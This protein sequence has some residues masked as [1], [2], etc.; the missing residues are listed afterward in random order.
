MKLGYLGPVGSFSYEAALMYIR[1]GG[2]SDVELV[3]AKNFHEIIESV[4][5][6]IV[7]EGILPLENSTEGVITPVV[8]AI[9]RT[10]NSYIKEE[11]VLPV[12]HNIYSTS[13]KIEDVK[14]IF[15]HPQP[16][17]QCRLYLYNNLPNVEI[18]SCDSS[19]SACKLAKEKGSKY[20]AI[21]NTTS[22]EIYNLNLL[23][24]NIQD[25]A[26]NRT[27]FIVIGRE[28]TVMTGNDK[29]SIAFTFDSDKPGSLF[30]V[31]KEFAEE[32]INLTRIESR[33]TKEQLGEYVFYVD[34][35]GH[36]D[37]DKI[38]DILVKVRTHTLLL[39]ILG[40]YKKLEM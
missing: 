11:L 32:G 7:E 17:E 35:T 13:E 23:A 27:R 1:D 6:G 40:S 36:V 18:L 15:S 26:H 34:F 28:R 5:N 31:M 16:K 29:T 39:K 14:Y 20:A 9:F 21:A 19:S 22:G 4:E 10:K 25:Y 37:D 38:K 33:P 8:D 3:A 24:E 12:Q 30:G 2:L